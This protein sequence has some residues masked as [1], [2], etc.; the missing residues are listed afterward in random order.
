MA[1]KAGKILELWDGGERDRQAIATQ[2]PCAR[3]YVDDVLRHAGRVQK[4]APRGASRPVPERPAPAPKLGR[5]CQ[6]PDVANGLKPCGR[7]LHRIGG[8]TI[9]VCRHHWET[10]KP[11]PGQQKRMGDRW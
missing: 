1:R 9:G 4:R 6:R 2:I 7:P 5:T 10:G 8:E 11:L 3:S